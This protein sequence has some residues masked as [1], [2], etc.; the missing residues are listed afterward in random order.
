M[1]KSDV[2][3]SLG[4]YAPDFFTLV[5]GLI[6]GAKG[7]R[8]GLTS[9]WFNIGQ[10]SIGD[11]EL[12]LVWTY[13][14]I[15]S[16]GSGLIRRYSTFDPNQPEKLPDGLTVEQAKNL[17]AGYSPEVC[18]HSFRKDCFQ[19]MDESVRTIWPGPLPEKIEYKPDAL[20]FYKSGLFRDYVALM[21][22]RMNR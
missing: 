10:R 2:I 7:K 5:V 22:K 17:I 11:V 6:V 8:F 16:G 12:I 21:K 4:S 15:P 18:I 9:D 3:C 19:L 20:R 13:L 14:A 1:D